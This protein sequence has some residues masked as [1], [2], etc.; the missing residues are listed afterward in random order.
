M[1]RSSSQMSVLKEPSLKA[2]RFVFLSLSLLFVLA[3][4][5]KRISGGEGARETAQTEVVGLQSGSPGLLWDVVAED[6]DWV[7]STLQRMSLEEKVGQLVMPS[8]HGYFINEESEDFQRLAR[9]VKERKVGGLIFFRGDVFETSYLINKLQSYA[10]VPLLI[11]ADFERGVAMRIDRTT[12]FPEIMALGATRDPTLS[13]KMGEVIAR[14]GRTLGIH[15]NFAPVVDVNNNPLNPVINTRAFGEDPQL[16]SEMADAF[17]KG[18]HAGKMISTAKHFPGHGDTEVDSHLDLP[19]LPFSRD[20]FE[21]VELPPFRDAIDHGV[22]SIMVAH[23]SV[24]AFDTVKGIPATLSPNIVTGLLKDE[25]HFKGL[26]VTDA[27][28]MQGVQKAY[29]PAEAAVLAVKAGNDIVLI[30]PDEDIAIDA[31]IGA[32]KR[33]E[34]S[35][36]RVDESVRKILELKAW[37]GLEKNRYVHQDTVFSVVGARDHQ[38]LADEIARR[39]I[40]LVKNESNLVPLEPFGS[41]KIA[42]LIVSDDASPYTGDR[43]A[44]QFR[45]RYP[46]GYTTRIDTRSNEEEFNSVFKD[47][48]RSDLIVCPIYLRARSGQGTIGLKPEQIDFLHRVLRLEKPV[49]TVSLGDPYVLADVSRAQ[50]HICAYSDVDVA[51]DAAVEALFGEID[52]GG[53][54]PITIPNLASYG[55][56]LTIKKS[57]LRID[58]PEVAG[59]DSEKLKHV[60]DILRKAVVD[61]AFP[62][63]VALVAK[64]GIIVY[65]KALG[66]Y[67]YSPYSRPIDVQTMFDLASVTKVVATT[68]AVMKLYDEGRLG[69]DD[70][71]AEYIPKFGQNGKDEV[72]IRNLLLHNSGLPSRK[73]FYE[74]CTSAAQLLDSLYETPL[75]YPTGDTTIYSD[76]GIIA[77]GKVIEKITGTTLDRYVAKEF[78]NPLHMDNTMF[79]PPKWRWDHIAPTEIDTVWRKQ[80]VPVRGT[81]HDENAAALGGVA[82]HAGLFSTA[83][84][85]A[86]FMQML[87]SGGTYGGKRFLKEETIRMFTQRQS[88]KS[89]RA[90]G[91]DTKSRSGYSSAGRLFSSNSFGHTGFTGTSIWADPE[92][93]LFVILLTNRVYPTRENR[94]I[95]DVR[96]AF[97]DA[98]IEALKSQD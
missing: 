44:R 21:K 6:S 17:I 57:R 75:I 61:S 80:N 35:I 77:L 9:L 49:V 22:M 90:L 71:V 68:S 56:G 59:F 5:D 58:E 55:S 26:V 64:D 60:D 16:V 78:F 7:E 39:S 36:S 23:L 67:D 31:L 94:K 52:V 62:A 38:L 25:L 83:P 3:F 34:I 92:R 76:L 89:S 63:A 41:K 84:D 10:D 98:V 73:K 72:T 79:N 96:P 81:V 20:R 33:G 48:Q 4:S 82:G 11:S 65:D 12:S 43:F 97:H 15:Q 47:L 69:L 88:D 28:T 8:A 86:I 70:P 29:S 13:F 32:V 91:W 19:I 18:I 95:F 53:K 74:T 45:S 51:V 46:N 42:T 54:L 1:E 24:P 50:A 27:M 93:N 14:E 87:M 30:P 66:A 40:T 37:L 2:G 85:L